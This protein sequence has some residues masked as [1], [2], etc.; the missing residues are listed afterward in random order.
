MRRLD[1]LNSKPSAVTLVQE[2]SYQLTTA[3]IAQL[4]SLGGQSTHHPK[5]IL[6]VLTKAAR[7][8][9]SPSAET[10]VSPGRD[11]KTAYR[12]LSPRTSSKKAARTRSDRDMALWKDTLDRTRNKSAVSIVGDPVARIG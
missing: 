7:L 8:S 9:N 3:E 6:R 1:W 11:R 2:K 4:D 10:L 12:P 5:D